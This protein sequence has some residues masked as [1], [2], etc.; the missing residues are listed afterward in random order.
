M[1]LPKPID[2]ELVPRSHFP[3]SNL[4][5]DPAWLAARHEVPWK[6][7]SEAELKVKEYLSVLRAC[8]L[9]LC[10]HLPSTSGL[11]SGILLCLCCVACE[12][13]VMVPG[14]PDM[15]Q[16]GLGHPHSCCISWFGAD[17][18]ECCSHREAGPS[19]TQPGEEQSVLGQAD[20]GD[21]GG[22]QALQDQTSP[23][24]GF[25]SHLS[26]SAKAWKGS[27]TLRTPT[28]WHRQP[29]RS[30]SWTWMGPRSCPEEKGNCCFR[31]VWLRPQLL[32]PHFWTLGSPVAGRGLQLQCL[33]LCDL[34]PQGPFRSFSKKKKKRIFFTSGNI[35]KIE[36]QIQT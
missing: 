24:S 35:G 8:E 9:G 22:P 14:G 5:R 12:T 17:T 10:S 3:A 29:K 2:V 32:C 4:S 16:A 26:K 13:R 19:V 15:A 20:C 31:A 21:G 1:R 36:Q 34:I 7:L 18:P 25:L 30:R 27:S 11:M 23:V 28:G 6:R 33:F